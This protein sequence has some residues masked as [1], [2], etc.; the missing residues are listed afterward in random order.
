MKRCQDPRIANR[1]YMELDIQIFLEGIIC[2]YVKS[3]RDDANETLEELYTCTK[4]W[5]QGFLARRTAEHSDK[6]P[7]LPSDP[8]H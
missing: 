3:C 4:F 1:T 2:E 7:S 5:V 6:V 8:G